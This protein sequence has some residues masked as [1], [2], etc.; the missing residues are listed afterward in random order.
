VRKTAGG[1]RRIPVAGVIAF[2]R[3]RGFDPRRPDLLGLPAGAHRDSREL[4]DVAPRVT[5]LLQA[6]ADVELRALLFG[7]YLAG[8][9]VA[10]LADDAIAPAFHA[11]GDA[12]QHGTLEVYQE[13]RAVEIVLRALYELAR[14]V[15]APPD[16]APSAVL[17]TLPG[18]PYTLP[19]GLGELVLREAGW[20]ATSLGPDHPPATLRAALDDLVPDLLCVSASVVL[21]RDAFVAAY[22]EVHDHARARG[23]AVAIGGRALDRELRDRLRY[24]AFCETMTELA[25]LA[26]TLA[27]PPRRRSRR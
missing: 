24:T 17:A 8:R 23:A 15:P 20:R 9:S 25:D 21:D 5:K 14:V 27:A 2:L 7:L 13:H 3:E 26:A 10:D 1:H 18:D 19:L 12:W 16:G 6:G 4:D 22:R 11:I